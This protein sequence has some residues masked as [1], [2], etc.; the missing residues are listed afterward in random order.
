MRL[1]IRP[2]FQ[3]LTNT[4]AVHCFRPLGSLAAKTPLAAEQ[5]EAIGHFRN[6]FALIFNLRSGNPPFI[7]KWLSNFHMK[8]CTPGI[9]LKERQAAIGKFPFSVLPI[10]KLVFLTVVV[11]SVTLGFCRSPFT[12]GAQL[13]HCKTFSQLVYFR[14]PE[15]FQPKSFQDHPKICSS[16]VFQE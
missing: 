8:G 15:D 9:T 14:W 3:Q 5:R 6:V 16:E 13:P 10:W 1:P 11:N 4:N 12:Q 7:W 2:S